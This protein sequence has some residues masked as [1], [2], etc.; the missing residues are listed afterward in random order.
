MSDPALPP[1][2]QY[3]CPSCHLHLITWHRTG[4]RLEMFHKIG[5]WADFWTGAVRLI[6]QSCQAST[7]VVPDE[8]VGL[9]RD[10]LGIAAPVRDERRRTTSG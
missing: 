4:R 7:G 8:L 3:E 2:V 9:L 6:C 5:L 10:R 1:V